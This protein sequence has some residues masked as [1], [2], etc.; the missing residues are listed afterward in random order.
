MLF[1]PPTP[2]PALH[3]A[4]R[5]F[6]KDPSDLQ[7]Q[8]NKKQ[9]RNS[10]SGRS[11]HHITNGCPEK[12]SHLFFTDLDSPEN[13]PHFGGHILRGP[14]RLLHNGRPSCLLTLLTIAGTLMPPLPA[15]GSELASHHVPSHATQAEIATWLLEISLSHYHDMHSLPHGPA[16]PAVHLFPLHLEALDR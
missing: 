16:F 8:R 4:G 6:A 1:E 12:A 9:G 5:K 13:F 2:L 15:S 14:T 11:R 7:T 10:P 3:S